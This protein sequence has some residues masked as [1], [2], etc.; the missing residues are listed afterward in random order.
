MI[1][2]PQRMFCLHCLA[3]IAALV[4]LSQGSVLAHSCS[5]GPLPRCPRKYT[6]PGIHTLLNGIQDSDITIERPRYCVCQNPPDSESWT[7]EDWVDYFHLEAWGWDYDEIQ[8]PYWEG[9]PCN[10]IPCVLKWTDPQLSGGGPVE[11]TWSMPDGPPD[12]CNTDATYRIRATFTELPDTQPP[13]CR[14]H[15]PVDP[16]VTRDCYI[17]I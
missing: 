5:C 6:G 7:V 14:P 13:P 1:A 4:M 17:H 15:W 12:L 16:P 8:Y 10:N 9:D 11:V 3:I 2:K